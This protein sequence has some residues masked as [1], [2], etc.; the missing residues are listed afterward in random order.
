[1]NMLRLKINME[2]PQPRHIER[3]AQILADGGVAVYPTD[4]TYGLG[5]DLFQ[6]KSIERIYQIKGM[7]PKQRL[8]FICADIAD[9]S[10]FHE[11]KRRNIHRTYSRS[12]FCT[13]H[14]SHGIR[15]I[16]RHEETWRSDQG[17]EQN[18]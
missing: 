11:D 12:C 1:M 17:F 7:D 15:W 13:G 10:A 14:D 5:C 4:T 2:H 6:K 16:Q 3:A 8:S 9:S 18:E